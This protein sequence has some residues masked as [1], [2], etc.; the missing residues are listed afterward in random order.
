MKGSLKR[1]RFE[2]EAL[3]PRCLLS[4]SVALLAPGAASAAALGTGAEIQH[5]VD[6]GNSSQDSS[7]YNPV[8][9]VGS[10]L[11]SASSA[12]ATTPVAATTPSTSESGANQATGSQ[13]G[14]TQAQN[15]QINSTGT[16]TGTG[17]GNTASQTSTGSSQVVG[18]PTTQ[19][20]TETLTAANAPP[21]AVTQTTPGAQAPVLPG[22]QFAGSGVE[23]LAGQVFYL[24]FSGASGVN[25]HGPVEVDGIN[26]PAFSL[27][28]DG[29][30]GQEEVV[31]SRTVDALN[32][33]FSPVGVTFTTSKPPANSEFSTI[34]IGGSGS[35]FAQYGTFWGLA[36]EVDAG[37]L[38]RKDNAFVFSDRLSFG[39]LDASVQTLIGVIQHEAG[40]LLGYKHTNTG[41]EGGSPLSSVADAGVSLSGVPQWTQQGPGPIQ[42]SSAVALSLGNNV[43][44]GAI[45]A[46]AVDPANPNIVYVGTVNGG[47]WM[48]TDITATATVDANQLVNPA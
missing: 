6:S 10:I 12:P 40:H 39:A 15:T 48:T 32:A 29:L 27:A 31:I 24:D 35:E 2:L 11:P 47:V 34:F 25:Y 30:A 8:A 23:S 26:I 5:Q 21:Q 4:G 7:A 44:A 42:G 38:N 28:A 22:L 46:I 9:Q 18:S 13:N 16:S 20:L 37:N 43:A 3:E 33:V 17:T 45:Q 36:E 14:Q 19:Q 41:A 1:S